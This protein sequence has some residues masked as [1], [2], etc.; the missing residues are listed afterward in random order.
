MAPGS[1]KADTGLVG[2]ATGGAAGG[3][4]GAVGMLTNCSLM[5]SFSL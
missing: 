1:A 5:N 2:C 3:A 4:C